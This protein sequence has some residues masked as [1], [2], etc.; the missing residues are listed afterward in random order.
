MAQLCDF[1]PGRRKARVE[2]PYASNCCLAPS[3]VQPDCRHSSPEDTMHTYDVYSKS[4]PHRC[5]YTNSHRRARGICT[6][7]RSSTG[8]RS[9]NGT[10]PLT[11][12][13]ACTVHHVNFMHA[14]MSCASTD[15]LTP[16]V[17]AYACLPSAIL[18]MDVK[19]CYC[20]KAIMTPARWLGILHDV[21]R[22][23]YDRCCTTC[24]GQPFCESYIVC[25]VTYPVTVGEH[26]IIACNEQGGEC[27]APQTLWSA[28]LYCI[29]QSLGMCYI[30]LRDWPGCV[31]DKTWIITHGDM[32]D[33]LWIR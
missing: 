27:H 7:R 15:L 19:K 29:N 26:S 13:A 25:V 1:A 32:A 21:H 9:E 23:S 22:P 28:A 14:L 33:R 20:F 24:A 5:M 12:L 17:H 8:L 30:Y 10:L 16:H 2:A 18:A 3:T 11:G 4:F 6:G 31:S